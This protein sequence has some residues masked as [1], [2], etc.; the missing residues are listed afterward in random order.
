VQRHGRAEIDEILAQVRATLSTVPGVAALALG[1]SHAR[2]TASGDSDIDVGL[3]YDPGRRPDFDELYAAVAR[4]DDRG[5]PD[6]YGRYGEWGPW[7]N[8][9]VWL[10]TAGKRVDILL[11]DVQR[12]RTVLRECASG[13]V[14]IAYQ[15]GHP[16]GFVSATYAGEVHHNIAFFDPDDV[17]AH[18]RAMTDPYPEPLARAIVEQ[19]G[20]EAAFAMGTAGSAARRGD[21]AY[22]CGCAFRAIACLTQVLFAA[23]R[24]YLTNEKGAVTIADGF[25]VAPAGY[26]ARVTE[27]VANLSGA[28]ADLTAALA[29][30]Q[31]VADDVLAVAR[32]T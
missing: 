13:T 30:L 22:V 12:V 3:Y 10:Q 27:A 7:I 20:W 23:E 32:R 16:H 15:V 24:R 17:L 29:T 21:A 25:A 11:R 9:G 4:L 14:Q 5:E 19:F 18:L 8:G 26:A 31:A 28:P 6:G 2:G 1:G